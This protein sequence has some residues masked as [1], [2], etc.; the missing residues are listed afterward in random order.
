MTTTVVTLNADGSTSTSV[1]ADDASGNVNSTSSSTTT[2]SVTFTAPNGPVTVTNMSAADRDVFVQELN[3]LL[4]QVNQSS[5]VNNTQV[6]TSLLAITDRFNRTAA[7]ATQATGASTTPVL[8]SGVP[9]GAGVNNGVV[10]QD[11]NAAIAQAY[12]TFMT[13]ERQILAV[14]QN[15]QSVA[16]TGMIGTVQA[17]APTLAF[18]FLQD[19]ATSQNAIVTADTSELQQINN[20]LQTYSAMQNL[21]NGTLAKFGASSTATTAIGLLNGSG[22]V[23]TQ[24]TAADPTNATQ[25][26]SL[27]S[28]FNQ[29]TGTTAS[30]LE[31][32][33]GIARPTLS[34]FGS[35][36]N[37]VAYTQQQWNDFGNNLS[38]TVTQLQQQSQTLTNQVNQEEQTQNQY[39][40]ESTNLLSQMQNVIQEIGANESAP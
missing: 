7:F 40:A 18:Y 9:V 4:A 28:M 24:I 30:P 27:V 33:Y 16:A 10:S 29:S 39:F 13:N 14:D 26:L 31:A 6:S 8:A 11:N 15:E 5:V 38:N 1:T 12:Q 35:D 34:L 23:A 22:N 36:G 2:N 19:N 3:L 20:L 17:G 32:L 21:V 25:D 37:L